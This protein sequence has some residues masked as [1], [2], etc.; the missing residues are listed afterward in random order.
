MIAV[1]SPV[2]ADPI[3]TCKDASGRRTM[4]DRPCADPSTKRFQERRTEQIAVDQIQAKD[5]FSARTK[6][7]KDGL[8]I[9][10]EALEDDGAGQTQGKSGLF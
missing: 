10:P 3:N 5:M 7:Q 1:A 9:S 4:T 6:V 2:F 8:P